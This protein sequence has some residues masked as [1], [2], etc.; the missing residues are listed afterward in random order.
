VH[1]FASQ[2]NTHCPSW[3]S[4]SNPTGTL[5]LDA[6]AHDWSATTLYA[7][8]PFPLITT[9]L[10]RVSLKGH[11]QLLIVT[12]W[13]RRLWSSLLLSLL[14][15]TQWQLPLRPDL[16]SQARGS[17]PTPPPVL[18]LAPE[19]RKWASLGIQDN[20]VSTVQ[21]TR[22]SSTNVSYN[23]RWGIFFSWCEGHNVA[24]ESCD[25]HTVLHFLQ[26]LLD[27]G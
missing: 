27:A 7:F 14:C 9:T 11:W 2:E 23:M 3:F 12:Y 17:G 13:P 22:A 6:L 10:D 15:G 1:L 4:I 20:V 18:G 16:L 5:G 25:V 26:S 19:R 24:P 8:P 21:N